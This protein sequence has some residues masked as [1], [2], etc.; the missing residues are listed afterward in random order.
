MDLV[1]DAKL[2]I[3]KSMFDISFLKL[4]FLLVGNEVE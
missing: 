2:G 4:V 1:I 3:V